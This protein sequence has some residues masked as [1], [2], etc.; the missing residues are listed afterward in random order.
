M[1]TVSRFAACSFADLL[2]KRK[3][4]ARRQSRSGSG[5]KNCDGVS[6]AERL[7]AKPISRQHLSSHFTGGHAQ[8]GSVSGSEAAC[9]F[10]LVPQTIGVVGPGAA[11][12]P[13]NRTVVRLPTYFS[14]EIVGAAFIRKTAAWLSMS[15]RVR[16]ALGYCC[17][18]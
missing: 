9:S 8:T 2:A 5:A 15:V 7:L 10:G 17:C 11:S 14:N 16:C 12:T 4:D 13:H 18:Q 1:L 3:F 6:P